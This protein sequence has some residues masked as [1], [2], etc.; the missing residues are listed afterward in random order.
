M[1][2]TTYCVED[3]KR[4]GVVVQE[5]KHLIFHNA[6]IRDLESGEIADCHMTAKGWEADRIAPAEYLNKMRYV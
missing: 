4:F 3:A 6:L 2:T 1:I 5:K